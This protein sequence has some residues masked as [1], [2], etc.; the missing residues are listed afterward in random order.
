MFKFNT[1]AAH[2]VADET[3]PEPPE[4]DLTTVWSP[5]IAHR[6]PPIP[7][8]KPIFK[9]PMVQGIIFLTTVTV[10]TLDYRHV[11]HKVFV[12]AACF[13]IIL[14]VFLVTL[15]VWKAQRAKQR[16]SE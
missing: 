2:P 12:S 1:T 15:F 14:D 4:A 8:K 7:K 13:S 16:T 5:A 6:V 9:E 3:P 11:S 10:L